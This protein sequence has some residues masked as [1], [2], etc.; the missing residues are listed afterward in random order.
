MS[1]APRS[2]PCIESKH[3]MKVTSRFWC[4][5]SGSSHKAFIVSPTLFNLSPYLTP[6]SI[7]GLST[8]VPDLL[9]PHPL[10]SRTLWSLVPSSA[11]G[12]VREAR[13]LSVQA[14][15]TRCPAHGWLGPGGD[16]S[17]NNRP[18]PLSLEG[19]KRW[20]CASPRLDTGL[21]CLG[22]GQAWAKQAV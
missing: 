15:R 7:S 1:E 2:V 3:S 12:I 6:V 13:A 11:P 21:P 16:W 19:D 9:L 20:R 10:P 5:W 8:G 4:A 14:Q 17:M 18:C 22:A